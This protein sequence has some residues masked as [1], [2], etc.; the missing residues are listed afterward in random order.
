MSEQSAE[1]LER[2][3]IEML[4]PW[5]VTGRLDPAEVAK[6]EGYLARHPQL[7]RQ[8][9]LV[10]SEQEQTV[11]ANEALGASPAG[12]LDRLMAQL[13]GRKPSRP[14][15]RGGTPLFQAIAE[16]FAAPT[17]SG[18]R[19]A[20]FAAAAL[21]VV[22]ATAITTLLMRDG[23]GAYQ[24]ASGQQTAGGIS[25]LIVFADDAKAQAISHLLAEF[26]ANIVDG[27]KAGG[28]YTIRLRTEDR[29]Q[30]ARDALLRRLA[31]RRD[32]VQTVFPS[33]D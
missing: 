1:E 25:A 33:R 4:L 30:T 32:V 31:E 13:P 28:V 15:S 23:S 3:E 9:D 5:Y 18:V 26:N 2:E 17:A 14:P 16:F 29:S 10:R 12:A 11:R 21:V 8:L 7:R 20:A 6:V 22:Q 19:W 27:P 24:A